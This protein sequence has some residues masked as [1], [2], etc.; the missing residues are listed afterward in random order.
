[1]DFGLTK[2]QK[3]IQKAARRFAKGEFDRDALQSCKCRFS[4]LTYSLGNYLFQ[5]YV[6]NS[7]YEDETRIFDNVILCQA[8][9]DNE[10]HEEWIDKIEAG[11]RITLAHVPVFK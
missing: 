11:K 2:E 10:G 3:D 5:N 9:V 7:R 1:M 4:L 8:D 6:T